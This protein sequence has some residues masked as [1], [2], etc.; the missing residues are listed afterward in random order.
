MKILVLPGDGIGPEIV[1]A[2]MHVLETLN[3]ARS[4]GLS[5]EYDDIGVASLKKH[6]TT[7]RSDMIEKARTFDGAILG[8]QDNLNY[9]PPSEGGVNI[10]GRFRIDLDLYA[11]ARPARTR[12]GVAN[13]KE[14]LDL[15]I[16]R[17]L[18]E[19]FYADRNMFAWGRASSCRLRTL[20]C[21]CARSRPRDASA[22][23]AP[24]SSW[25]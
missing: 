14:G 23:R 17:E 7:M 21:P 20:P 1:S 5:F 9:P 13:G 25:P 22:L 18:T 6:G 16:M 19:G 2:G 10:S 12:P 3:D 8:P 11:N 24:L 15:V 4:L